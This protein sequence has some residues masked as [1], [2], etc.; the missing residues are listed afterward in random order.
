MT[1]IEHR[2]GDLHIIVD[3]AADGASTASGA[4]ARVWAS[5]SADRASGPAFHW[6]P[7]STACGWATSTS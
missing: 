1:D 2:N 4:S 3:P 7:I 5:V 6:C